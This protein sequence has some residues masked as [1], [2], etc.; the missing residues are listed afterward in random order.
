MKLQANFLPNRVIELSLSAL[1]PLNL[2]SGYG[3]LGPR[4]N[5]NCLFGWP[6]EIVA[7]QLIAWRKEGSLTQSN[8]VSVTRRMRRFN[9]L[10]RLACLQG[11]SGI[12]S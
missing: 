3:N 9:T 12:A 2:G 6:S 11:N 5:A 8:A 1:S 4:V 7:G 10:L